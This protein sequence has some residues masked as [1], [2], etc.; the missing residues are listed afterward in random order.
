MNRQAVQLDLKRENAIFAGTGGVS[1]HACKARFLPAFKDVDSGR[2]EL[3]RKPDGRCATSHIISGL[4]PE[5]ARERDDDGRI[6]AIRAGIVA[7]FVRDDVFYT[8]EEAAV[9]VEME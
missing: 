2:V 3:A 5:W 6:S 8:R 7:G 4:P 9:I 1:Q